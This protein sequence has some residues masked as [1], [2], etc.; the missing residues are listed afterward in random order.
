MLTLL[1]N[2]SVG[3]L[4]LGATHLDRPLIEKIGGFNVSGGLRP[5]MIDAEGSVEAANGAG[6]DQN[7][8]AIMSQVADAKSLEIDEVS[9]KANARGKISLALA[10]KM[11]ARPPTTGPR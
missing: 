1:D 8:I 9:G 6:E 5:P 3:T 4:R 10:S 2:V 11:M 7:V